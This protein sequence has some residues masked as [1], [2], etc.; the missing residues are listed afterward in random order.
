MKFVIDRAAFLRPLNHAQSVVERRNTIPIL[1]NILIACGDNSIS[2]T[3]SDMDSNLVESVEAAVESKGEITVPAHTLHDIVRK[4]P[5]GAEVA[6]EADGEGRVTLKAGRSRFSLQTLAASDFPTLAQDNLPHSFQLPAGELRTL[7]DRT[8]FA[9]SREETRYYLNGIFLHA[10]R[11]GDVDVLRAVATDGHRLAR[12]EMPLPEGAAGM[13]DVIIPRKV[14]GELRRLIDQADDSVTISLSESRIEFSFGK[15]VLSSKLIDG[16]FPDYERVI[17]GGNDKTLEVDCQSFAEA[18]DRVA[19]IS[20][21]RSRAV[22]LSLSDGLLV[23]SASNQ[24]SGM[25]TEEIPVGYSDAP[26]EIGFNS[27]YLLDIAKQIE[28]E[29]AQLSLADPASPT[30]IRDSADPASLYVLMPM[31]V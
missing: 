14:V 29:G 28:G 23:L 13:P 12:V 25:A 10:K 19:T 6:F 24:E 7:I 18:V 4:L 31:R 27:Q 17:P 22:K 3:A 2:L 30:I 9:I 8:Q 21:E 5:D 1:S 26:I 15:V 11:E 20:T 16:T